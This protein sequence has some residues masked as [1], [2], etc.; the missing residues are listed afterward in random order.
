MTIADLENIKNASF[1]YFDDGDSIA[2]VQ[3][4]YRNLQYVKHQ[5]I[6]ICKL[7]IDIDP[8][9]YHLVANKE[10]V[11]SR[12]A[13]LADPFNLFYVPKQTP[14]LCT[15]AIMN[16]P[17]MFQ[18]VLNQTE[19]ICLCAIRADANS[20]RYVKQITP[21]ICK[22]LLDNDKVIT[23]YVNKFQLI[24]L[25][26]DMRISEEDRLIVHAIYEQKVN[27][28]S[29]M[30]NLDI[31]TDSFWKINNGIRRNDETIE[32]FTLLLSKYQT[33]KMCLHALMKYN[34][35]Y[36][37]I[38]NKTPAVVK[39]AMELGDGLEVLTMCKTQ[40]ELMCIEFIKMN[41]SNISLIRSPSNYMKLLAYENDANNLKYIHF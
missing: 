25:L 33:E 3:E 30:D 14:N 27:S 18:F 26:M 4:D 12:Y 37:L 40:D 5:T 17:D 13:V 31:L 16:N 7:A 24:D 15:A 32:K 10:H 36:P 1:K 41:S 35:S 21:K 22:Y 11:I 34:F 38:K 19:T 6:E 39:M 20:L 2:A 9:A 8:V 29:I 23:K 28:I